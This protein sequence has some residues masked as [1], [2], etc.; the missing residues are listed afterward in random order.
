[1]IPSVLDGEIRALSPMLPP[2]T[3]ELVLSHLSRGD[4]LSVLFTSSFFH[5][6]A[7]RVLYRLLINIPAERAIC[8]VKTLVRN[9]FYSSLVRRFD[10]EWPGNLLT[11]NF[12]RLLRRALHRLPHLVH[13]G[14]EFSAT[15]NTANLA[16]ILQDCPFSLRVFTT[17]MRC[18]PLLARFLDT[19]PDLLEI[20]LRGFPPSSSSG[21]T[22]FTLPPSALP[23]LRHFRTVLAS[24]GVTASFMRGRPIESVSMSLYPGNAAS[25][26]DA[27]LLA[28]RPLRRLTVMSFDPG[29]PAALIADIAARLPA[30]EALHA[31][32]LMRHS[33]HARLPSLPLSLWSRKAGRADAHSPLFFLFGRN[34]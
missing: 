31:V 3:T 21:T 18:E 20:C 4:L 7:A 2:E 32:V 23:R 16:W 12:L 5:Q 19:Q 30:L 8:L 33:T 25:S 1:M 9:D 29:S 28:T 13:L 24:P 26:L 6:L 27:L 15:D 11:A 34:S 14:L 10:L 22:G 17:S